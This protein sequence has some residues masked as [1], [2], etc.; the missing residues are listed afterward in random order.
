MRVGIAFMACMIY[1]RS[2]VEDAFRAEACPEFLFFWGHRPSKN[3]RITAACLSQWWQA[4]FE[5]GGTHYATS[6]HWMMAEK[7]RL[8][9]D[10]ETMS[11]ILNAT[12]PEDAKKLGR[13][14][15]RFDETV[16]NRERLR[17]VE[18]GNFQKF[19]Q[20]DLL[21]DFLI[22][23]ADL[24]LVEASP[25]DRVWGIGLAENDQRASNPLLWRGENLLGFC[26]MQVR[27]RLRC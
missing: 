7:A 12:S 4:S 17:V 13:Q 20:N 19:K 1:D 6:E 27:D 21:R 26:L 3:R 15:R 9:Q 5:V 25:V 14:V 22:S 8:F 11:R 24:V 10:D 16:W 2:W 23:T 18:E